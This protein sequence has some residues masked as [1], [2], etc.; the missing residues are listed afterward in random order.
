MVAWMD[1]TRPLL[2]VNSVRNPAR[3]THCAAAGEA[4][5]ADGEDAQD[6]L[7]V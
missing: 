1:S 4:Q 3:R 5:G 7:A 2:T 6:G